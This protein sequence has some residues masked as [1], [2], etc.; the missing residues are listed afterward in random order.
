MAKKSTEFKAFTVLENTKIA[1]DQHHEEKYQELYKL[2]LEGN[3]SGCDVALPCKRNGLVVIDIDVKGDAHKVDGRQWWSDWLKK[4]G[5][6]DTYIVRTM[7]GGLHF[8][9]SL[10]LM[11]MRTPFHPKKSLAPGV[12][13][14]NQRL[15]RSTSVFR[16]NL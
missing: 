8:Y 14:K 13:R 3:L 15:R 11:W 4:N 2:K 9:Y 5:G 7:S 6:N 12:E 1:L 10:L 16:L